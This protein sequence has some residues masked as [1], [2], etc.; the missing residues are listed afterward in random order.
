[1]STSQFLIRKKITKKLISK[2]NKK[3]MKNRISSLRLLKKDKDFV[4]MINKY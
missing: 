3:T 4:F 2:S 1:M